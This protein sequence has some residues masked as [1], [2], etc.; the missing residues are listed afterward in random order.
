[1]TSNHSRR[2]LAGP[3]PT[4]PPRSPSRHPASV[5]LAGLRRAAL[6]RLMETCQQ[7]DPF[8]FLIYAELAGAAIGPVE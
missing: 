1:V 4:G 2:R 5:T 6:Y 7:S 8:R 3:A